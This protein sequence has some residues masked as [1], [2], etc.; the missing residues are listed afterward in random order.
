MK[1]FRGERRSFV[2]HIG[3]LALLAGVLLAG[4]AGC[5]PSFPSETSTDG[6]VARD[7]TTPATMGHPDAAPNEEA[8][9]ITPGADAATPPISL[10]IGASCTSGASCAS[11][12][13]ADGVCCDEACTDSC[14]QCNLPGLV[15]ACSPV[16][17]R[18]GPLPDPYGLPGRR[19]V[20]LPARRP[21]RWES[22]LRVVAQRHELRRWVVQLLGQR[23]RQRVVLRRSRHLQAGADSDVRAI[24]VQRRGHGLLDDLRERRRLRGTALRQR[25]LRRRR[26]TGPRAPPGHDALPATASTATA[27]ERAATLARRA[28][29]PGSGRLP[30][31][32]GGPAAWLAG[33]VLRDGGVPGKL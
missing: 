28:T 27:A 16:T 8:S 23:R 4:V 7:A 31:R 33:R 17:R 12:F 22:P 9:G 24:Q 15:G 13:C 6:G 14:M 5:L 18:A 32:G 11:T 3:Q 29:S 21:L 30:D 20:D 1:W 19:R 10:G 26:Q 25:L 2:A